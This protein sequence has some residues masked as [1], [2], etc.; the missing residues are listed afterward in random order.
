MIP[1]FRRGFMIVAMIVIVLAIVMLS[2]PRTISGNKTI[3]AEFKEEVISP[4]ETTLLT[5]TIK[6][7]L[8][9]DLKDIEVEAIPVDLSSLYIMNGIQIED[10]IG[11][12]ETREFSFPVTVQDNVRPGVYSVEIDTNI[13]DQ[14]SLRI[15]IEVEE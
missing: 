1:V 12:G 3:Q 11:K 9:R 8:G 6:N 14:G 13:K 2:M 15:S 7:N 5:V 4:G 10:V